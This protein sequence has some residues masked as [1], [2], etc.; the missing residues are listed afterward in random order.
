VGQANWRFGGASVAATWL[1]V[2]Q[3]IEQELIGLRSPAK[4]VRD[5]DPPYRSLRSTED[6]Q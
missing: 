3:G 6:T 4:N 2:P 1:A 5:L